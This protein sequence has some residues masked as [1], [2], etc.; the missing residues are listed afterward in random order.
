M[1]IARLFAGAALATAAVSFPAQAQVNI[2]GTTTG[3][4]FQGTRGSQCNSGTSTAT[5]GNLTFTGGAFDVTVGPSG[6]QYFNGDVNNSLGR[7]VMSNA[8]FN[9]D[10]SGSNNAYGFRLFV[11]ITAPTTNP[12]G[13]AL[14]AELEGDMNMN[15][16]GDELEFDF[17]SSFSQFNYTNGYFEFRALDE[18]I[19]KN[20]TEHLGFKIYCA[21]TKNGTCTPPVNQVPEPTSFAL[22]AAGLAGIVGVARR[23]RNNV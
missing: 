23:R 9:F 13:T 12:T 3:C 6:W 14:I 7:L 20:Q 10:P 18:D 21:D 15:S 2:K 17:S 11:N 5:A 16:S 22:V 1:K 19:K 4:F 8:D